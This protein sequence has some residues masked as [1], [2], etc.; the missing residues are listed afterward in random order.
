MKTIIAGSRQGVTLKD[1]EEAMAKCGW[2]ITSVVSGCARGV[3]TMGAMIAERRGIPVHEYPADW[4]TYGKSAGSFRN[5]QMANNAEA[6]I[7][8][9]DGKSKGTQNMIKGATA[10]GLRVF[11]HCVG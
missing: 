6:L 3:D 4:E 5:G 11:V 8:V 1:V 10:R 9:W 2:V 7:A